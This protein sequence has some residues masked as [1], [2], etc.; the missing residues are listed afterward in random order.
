MPLDIPLKPVER[1][2]FR[3]DTA[4]VAQ[5][6]CPANHP[7]FHDSGPASNHTFVFP[8]TVTSIT[9]AD[10]TQFVGSPNVVSFYNQHDT[11]RREAIS[12]LD[13]SDWY[14]VA[15]EILFDA[16]AEFAPVARD[17]P[18][19]F[20][21]TP[22]DTSIYVE[23]RRLFDRLAANTIDTAEVE[24]TVLRLLG[25]VLTAA[26]RKQPERIAPG[27]R[28]AVIET[29]RALGKNAEANVRLRDLARAHGVSPFQLCRGFARLSGTTLTSYRNALRVRIALDRLRDRRADLS[30]LALSLG[31]SSHSHFT[32]VFRRHVGVTPSAYRAGS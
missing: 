3:S 19:R 11:Y 1:I 15:D 23:Q 17:R 12:R 18:F 8:R 21:F 14:V 28:R 7:L 30:D 31:F 27:V 13:A 5:F 26:Y 29:Q 20:P 25:R 6:R 9:R 2:L 32:A 4:A 24:E 16:I 22:V 10:G